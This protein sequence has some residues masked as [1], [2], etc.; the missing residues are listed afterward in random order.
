MTYSVARGKDGANQQA[1]LKRQ[2][3]VSFCSCVRKRKKSAHV[4][5]VAMTGAMMS[6]IDGPVVPRM[7]PMIVMMIRMIAP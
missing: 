1:L 5:M 7:E 4:M 2:D 3:S 6:A